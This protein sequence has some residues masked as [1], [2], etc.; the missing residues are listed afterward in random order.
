MGIVA[1]ICE[2]DAVSPVV[3]VAILLAITVLLVAVTGSFVLGLGDRTGTEVPTA[4]FTYE[5]SQVD[6]GELTIRHESGDSLVPSNIKIVTD[7]QF[8]PA[9]GNA[10]VPSGPAYESLPLDSSVGGTDWVRSDISAGSEFGIVG[11]ATDSLEKM[12]VRIVWVDP[13]GD[14]TVPLAEWSG[15]DA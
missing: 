8:H 7:R 11:D 2:D 12:T 3:G 10:S 9:P 5:Y 6:Y 14:R 1:L 4:E 13:S 15:P